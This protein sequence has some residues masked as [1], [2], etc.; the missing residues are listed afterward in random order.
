V[1]ENRE[2]SAGRHQIS[3]L[4]VGALVLA[5]CSASVGGERWIFEKPGVSAAELERDRRECF[6]RSI[7]VA[8]SDTSVPN[9]GFV[10]VD[11]K[12]YTECME[13]RGYALRIDGQ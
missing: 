4:V 8:E 5:G 12:A 7:N 10:R 1:I 9:L 6:Y 3:W 11:R 13:A 2:G